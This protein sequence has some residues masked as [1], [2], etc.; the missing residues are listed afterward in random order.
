MSEKKATQAL[1]DLKA[2]LNI[3]VVEEPSEE[4]DG[5]IINQQPAAGLVTQGSDI[6]LT[7]AI[8]MPI[9]KVTIPTTLYGMTQS[10]AEAALRAL[11]LNPVIKT[12]KSDQ[13]AA[14][15]VF[16]VTPGLGDTVDEGS[17]VTLFVSKGPGPAPE[18]S[19]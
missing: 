4:P 18:P 6:V 16:G 13:A 14:G 12:E 2:N 5:D 19:P 17:D 8:P 3:K 9:E 11:G 1:K 10:D 7:V 15:I